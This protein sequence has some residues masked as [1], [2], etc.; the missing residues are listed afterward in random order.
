MK[1]YLVGGAVR[2]IL[3]GVPPKDRDYVVVGS[4][5]AEML[6]LGFKQV[7]AD[8]P[9][10]LNP[11]TQEEYALARRERKVA[12]GY[13]GFVTEHGSEVTLEEDLMR[14]DLTINSMAMDQ[15]TNTLIDPFGGQND[16]NHNILRH[17][18]E[19]FK[20]DPV[21]ILR[22][23]RFAARYAHCGFE[24]ANE[25]L[26]LMRGMVNA[27]EFDSLVPERVWAEFAKGLTERYPQRMFFILD[28][29]GALKKLP[30]YDKV[31]AAFC[32]WSYDDKDIARNA[33]V[34]FSGRTKE[35]FE[36]NKLPS[37]IAE[38]AMTADVIQV[39]LST[40]MS[41][42]SLLEMFSKADVFRRP[43]R[44]GEALIVAFRRESK[45]LT[46]NGS[47]SL[48]RIMTIV[49]AVSEVDCG[50]IASGCEDKAQIAEK[51]R[52]ARLSVIRE[53]F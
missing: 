34:M 52:A 30:F 42:E 26:D 12:P 24:V 20:E 51:I 49:N 32:C 46:R 9:V 33:A 44:F 38:L 39:F 43:E 13:H 23:A 27:G 21:R 25:T 8:F 7:G 31:P 40:K 41:P 22:V 2:D 36:E 17:T 6:S 11:E 28:L 4:S 3:M 15:S 18:S 48:P 37:V 29:V 35:E 16:L 45:Q 19:A 50:A 14:R 53:Y 47:I 10:F 1:I 5:P